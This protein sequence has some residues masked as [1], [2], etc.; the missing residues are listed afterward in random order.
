M[1]KDIQTRFGQRVKTLRKKRGWTQSELAEYL[2][3]DRGYISELERGQRNI[4][5]ATLD[6]IAKGFGLTPSRMLTGL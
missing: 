2:G 1:A 5:L 3:L 4:T 6:V